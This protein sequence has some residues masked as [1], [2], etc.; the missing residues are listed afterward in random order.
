MRWAEH[1]T[2]MRRRKIHTWSWW[3]KLNERD[4]LETIG[5]GGKRILKE[6]LNA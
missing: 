6:G 1:I 3:E 2:C 4:H 5:V